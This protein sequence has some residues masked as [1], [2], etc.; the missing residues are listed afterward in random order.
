VSRL[1]RWN[2]LKDLKRL[3]GR[4]C[5][6]SGIEGETLGGKRNDFDFFEPVDSHLYGMRE[7]VV[8]GGHHLF[9]GLHVLAA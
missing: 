9:E 3:R 2:V 6:E 5:G 1:K 7:L 8:R 4:I